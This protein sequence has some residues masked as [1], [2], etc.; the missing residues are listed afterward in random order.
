MA[1]FP[2]R[3]GFLSSPSNQ[4]YGA[5]AG[6]SGRSVTL[7]IYLNV[8]PRLF[9]SMGWDNDS[10]LRPPTGQFFIRQTIWVWRATVEW[11]WQGNPKNCPRATLSTW[12]DP[13]ANPGHRG[14]RSATDRLSY[15]PA[16]AK[17][18]KALPPLLQTPQV[19]GTLQNWQWRK[20]DSWYAPWNTFH[21]TQFT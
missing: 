19:P 6:T 14:E 4:F 21:F 13:G 11:Y 1:R 5:Q 17:V 8:M 12:T 20:F 15:G 18:K 10:E 9:M 7:T 2:A 3:A 16:N